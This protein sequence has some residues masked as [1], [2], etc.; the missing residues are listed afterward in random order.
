MAIVA[1]TSVFT[2][3]G[4]KYAKDIKLGDWLFDRLGQPVQVTAIQTYRSEE[5][6]RVTM[7]DGTLVEGDAHLSFPT[8]DKQYRKKTYTYTG[9]IS[10]RVHPVERSV[11]EMADKG[12]TYRGGRKYFSVPT[13]EPLQLPTQ[14]L[15]VPPFI[16][17]FWFAAL[18]SKKTMAVPL[19][20]ADEV[21]EIF[22]SHGYKIVKSS[23]KSK[24]YEHFS[25]EP[26][27]WTQCGAKML[28]KIP[29]N[30]LYASAEQRLILLQG[31]L[32]ARQ[33][34]K[35]ENYRY[36]RIKSRS[37]D[38]LVTIQVLAESLGARTSSYLD[39]TLNQRM[40]DILRF[41]PILNDIE[42]KRGIVHLERRTISKIE[43]IP[44]QLCVHIETEGKAQSFSVNEGFITCH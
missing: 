38:K 14:P 22:R 39:R 18:K 25:T 8:E 27:L 13:T 7:S 31:V 29:Q 21:Y 11:T 3:D 36:S 42:P 32:R 6:Y 30:Y 26:C 12:L 9:K 1:K 2:L 4:W 20:L 5:C 34:K 41:K 44:A 15:P 35:A 17:G 23:M 40:L 43:P 24:N 16:F 33:L 10:R 28:R 19:W 37:L